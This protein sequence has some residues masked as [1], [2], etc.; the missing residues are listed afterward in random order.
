MNPET[1]I[2]NLILMALSKAGCLYLG[3]KVLE[4]GS[5]R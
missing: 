3:M 5:A 2:Q 1:K 4:P